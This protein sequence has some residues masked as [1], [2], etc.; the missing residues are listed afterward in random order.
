M[1]TNK[2]NDLHLTTCLH[3]I[4]GITFFNRANI[5]L[6]YVNKDYKGVHN[7]TDVKSYNTLIAKANPYKK[8]KIYL[9]RILGLFEMLGH[10]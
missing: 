8:V 7:C 3:C 6:M 4:Y 2:A 1:Y 10:S 9:L 5:I